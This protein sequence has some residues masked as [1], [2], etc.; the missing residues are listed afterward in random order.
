[1]TS[2]NISPFFSVVDEVQ[3]AYPRMA[4]R[5]IIA[6]TCY[7][8]DVIIVDVTSGK[9]VMKISTH[10]SSFRSPKYF[11]TCSYFVLKEGS[12]LA[13]TNTGTLRVANFWLGVDP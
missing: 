10:L 8:P 3:L 6:G 9:M 13:V 2:F 1:V 11:S 5:G 4:I 7:A 12:F